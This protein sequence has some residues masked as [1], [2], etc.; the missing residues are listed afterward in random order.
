M[1]VNENHEIAE[2]G[3]STTA[4]ARNRTTDAGSK[5]GNHQQDEA[6]IAS[7]GTLSAAG[8]ANVANS[9]KRIASY[10]PAAATPS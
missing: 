5:T 2:G 10:T 8:R 7:L 4:E 9:E 1:P 6:Q 3:A